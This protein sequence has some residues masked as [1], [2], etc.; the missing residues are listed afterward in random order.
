MI[1]TRTT[2]PP[3][4]VHG[5]YTISKERKEKEVEGETSFNFPTSTERKE[6][7]SEDPA[8][9]PSFLYQFCLPEL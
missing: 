9:N 8:R 2:G 3:A 7:G 1:A 5:C 6:H 4:T